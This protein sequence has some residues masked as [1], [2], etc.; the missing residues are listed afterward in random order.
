MTNTAEAET[1]RPTDV[2]CGFAVQSLKL[3][4]F[5]SYASASLELDAGM[6]VFVGSNGAGKTNILEAVSLLAPGRGLRSA[7][8]PDFA[9]VGGA[10]ALGCLC[11]D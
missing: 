10:G 7:S 11:R 5:R 8:L 1:T 3:T 4:D 2:R 9:R 6:N